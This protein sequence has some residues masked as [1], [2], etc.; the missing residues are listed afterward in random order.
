MYGLGQIVT[1][2]GRTLKHVKFIKI[3]KQQQ[4]AQY[5]N[6]LRNQLVKHPRL[7]G[8]EMESQNSHALGL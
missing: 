2:F 4:V 3:I 6:M 7:T 1:E 5:V 8:E